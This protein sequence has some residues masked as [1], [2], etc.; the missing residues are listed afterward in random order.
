[1]VYQITLSDQEYAAL[2]AAAPKG[3]TEP[4]QLLH[5][6]IQRL[7]KS[8]QKNLYLQYCHAHTVYERSTDRLATFQR[9][10]V[11]L[12]G[13]RPLVRNIQGYR[14]IASNSLLPKGKEQL[15]YLVLRKPARGL[16]SR[17]IT[18]D[19]TT[20]ATALVYPLFTRSAS[21]FPEAAAGARRRDARS[22][23]QG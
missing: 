21:A 13:E 1:M 7:Q 4:E 6:M 17:R 8:S 5:D 10:C 2:V 19:S 3:G 11:T 18:P 22:S 20:L 12:A 9:D 16:S 14:A 15:G 23:G